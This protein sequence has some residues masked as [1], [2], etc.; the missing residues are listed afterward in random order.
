MRRFL[1][2]LALGACVLASAQ[3]APKKV[4]KANYAQAEQFT[5]K[6]LGQMVY[7]TRIRPN[8]F[9]NSDKFWYSWK[10]AEGTQYFIVDPATGVRKPVFDMA[11]LAR[12]L[13][14]IP[15][16]PMTPSTSPSVWS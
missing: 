2:V 9:K 1:T 5:A 10:T 4:V 14:E 12:Q 11:A 8:W 15:A 16:I 7:S 13:T 3:Q 6:K